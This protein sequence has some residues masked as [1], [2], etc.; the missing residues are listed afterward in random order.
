MQKHKKSQVNKKTYKEWRR[1]SND[2]D[3]R[4]GENSIFSLVRNKMLKYK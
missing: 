2:T 1:F 3:I 4:K